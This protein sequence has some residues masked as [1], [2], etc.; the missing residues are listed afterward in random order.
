VSTAGKYRQVRAH[1]AQSRGIAPKLFYSMFAVLFA[2]NAA[3]GLAFYMSG[4][5]ARILGEQNTSVISAYED[6]LS[7]M[8]VEI[9]RLHSRVYAQAGDINMQLQ[10][11]VQQQDVLMEQQQLVRALV[12][13]AG[14]MGIASLPVPSLPEL[15]DPSDLLATSDAIAFMLNETD[16]VMEGIAE[17][18]STRTKNIASELNSLGIYSDKLSS[19]PAIGGPLLP[20]TSG[21]EARDMLVTANHVMSAL[22]RY[23][24]ARASLEQAPVH[25]P[26]A[27]KSYRQSSGFGNRTDPFTR[28]PAFHAGLDFAAPTGTTVLAAGTGRVVFVGTKAGYG[29]TVEIEHQSGLTSRYSHLS[30]YLVREGQDVATGLPIAHVGSTGRSTGPHLHFEVRKGDQALNPKRFLDVGNRL[31]AQPG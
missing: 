8:R 30:A 31:R 16:A 12:D 23:N 18:A 25:L 22:L 24:S 26:L 5:L 20:P 19:E 3:T 10:E 9:D 14:Q 7:Q 15:A 13:K 28:T 21:P 4:D 6:R 27:E 17:T 11:V 2:T 1:P 29:K